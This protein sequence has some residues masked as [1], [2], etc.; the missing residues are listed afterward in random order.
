MSRHRT[1]RR[2]SKPVNFSLNIWLNGQ[3]HVRLVVVY[4]ITLTVAR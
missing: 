4:V 1:S 2:P 3:T